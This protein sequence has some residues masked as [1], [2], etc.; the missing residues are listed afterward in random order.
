M[1]KYIEAQLQTSLNCLSTTDEC[2][3]AWDMVKSRFNQILAIQA[4]GW[5]KGQEVYCVEPKTGRRIWGVVDRVNPKTVTVIISKS[6][7]P[8]DKI[9]ESVRCPGSTLHLAN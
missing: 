5:R 8:D 7:R 9:G 3:E 6:E 2:R 1:D 4:S